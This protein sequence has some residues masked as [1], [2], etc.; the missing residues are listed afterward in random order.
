MKKLTAERAAQLKAQGIMYVASIV[1]SHYYTKYYKW[2]CTETILANGGK[3]PPYAKYNGFVH[4]Y[5][6]REIDWSCT[7]R[8][9]SI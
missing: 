9:N 3:M 8:W 5:N 1:K 4:G 6:G 7:I 2:E